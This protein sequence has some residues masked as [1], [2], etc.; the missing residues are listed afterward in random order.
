[1]W[2]PKAGG[3]QRGLGIPNMV[4][5]LVQQAVHRVLRPNYEPTFHGSSHGFRPA[6]SCHTAVVETVRHLEEGTRGWSRAWNI[7]ATSSL[8]R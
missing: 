2:I 1:M 5:R 4:D 3:G 7:R 6:R 8:R